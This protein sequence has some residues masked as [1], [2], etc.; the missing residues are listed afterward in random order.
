MSHNK[1]SGVGA[2]FHSKRV[3]DIIVA[4]TKGVAYLQ[5]GGKSSITSPQTDVCPQHVSCGEAAGR[6]GRA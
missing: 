4:P 2:L 3:L 5:S 6:A 1:A